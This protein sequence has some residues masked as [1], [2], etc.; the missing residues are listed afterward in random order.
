MGGRWVRLKEPRQGSGLGEAWESRTKDVAS[1]SV[2][3]LRGVQSGTAVPPG[4]VV[5]KDSMRLGEKG[6]GTLHSLIGQG[7]CRV[8]QTA[9][10]Q[11]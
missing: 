8:G 5:R 2:R 3:G 10:P 11:I 4:S 7:V 9:Q 1:G 6:L